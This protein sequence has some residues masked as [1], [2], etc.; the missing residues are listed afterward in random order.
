MVYCCTCNTNWSP[1]D[2]LTGIEYILYEVAEESH[3]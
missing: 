2:F 1:N 3:L